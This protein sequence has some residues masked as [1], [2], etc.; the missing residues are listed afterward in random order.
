MDRRYRVVRIPVQPFFTDEFMFKFLMDDRLE[1]DLK[2]ECVRRRDGTWLLVTDVRDWVN[3]AVSKDRNLWYPVVIGLVDVLKL[4]TTPKRYL[5]HMMGQFPNE[6]KE[7]VREEEKQDDGEGEGEGQGGQKSFTVPEFEDQLDWTNQEYDEDQV[8]VRINLRRLEKGIALFHHLLRYL[9]IEAKTELG[10]S[11]LQ[12]LVDLTTTLREQVR[13]ILTCE[14]VHH[15]TPSEIEYMQC[16]DPEA[17]VKAKIVRNDDRW[18]DLHIGY[19]VPSRFRS[20]YHALSIDMPFE[21]VAERMMMMTTEDYPPQCGRRGRLLG[22]KAKLAKEE[23]EQRLAKGSSLPSSSWPSSMSSMFPPARE[24]F[25]WTR[26]MMNQLSV[27]ARMASRACHYGAP[28]KR[29]A[30]L[31]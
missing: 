26:V 17:E 3:R 12:E 10:Q 2:E 27:D 20:L 18:L 8:L 29:A 1:L 6:L 21:W 14:G 11:K 22:Q 16:P 31:F 23:R 30:I 9:P 4:D 19:E 25:K 7:N 15:V 5:Q 13:A 28:S 24:P